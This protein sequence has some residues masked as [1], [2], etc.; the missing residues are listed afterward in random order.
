MNLTIYNILGKKIKTMIN[1]QEKEAG[2]HKVTFAGQGL[3]S[4]VYLVRLTAG[5]FNSVKKLMLIK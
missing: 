5:E 4:G 2:F 1:N 3:A